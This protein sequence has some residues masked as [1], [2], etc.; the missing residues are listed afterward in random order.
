MLMNC[1]VYN[2]TLGIDEVPGRVIEY[3]FS[4]NI[5]G[6]SSPDQGCLFWLSYNQ[7]RNTRSSQLGN[8]S[9]CY[10]RI[11]HV[12]FFLHHTTTQLGND[13]NLI[14]IYAD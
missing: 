6:V 9:Q 11:T 10:Q 1:Q 13:A 4:N 12:S 7:I 2:R 5:Y 14:D 8:R 3:A